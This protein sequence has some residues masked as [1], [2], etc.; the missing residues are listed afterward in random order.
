MKRHDMKVSAGGGGML[1]TQAYPEEGRP[2][3]DILL[4]VIIVKCC[5]A[6][7]HTSLDPLILPGAL[8]SLILHLHPT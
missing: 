7:L 6:L 3:I 8:A 4:R 2:D 1:P 5:E